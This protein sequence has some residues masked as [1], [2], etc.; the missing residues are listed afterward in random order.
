MMS[1]NSSLVKKIVIVTKSNLLADSIKC[2]LPNIDFLF[3]SNNLQK[4]IDSHSKID[5]LIIDFDCQ[6]PE[7]IQQYKIKTIVTITNGN[8]FLKDEI[9]IS[10][11][12]K[13]NSLLKIIEGTNN[14][15]D[16]F[17]VINDDF[18]YNERLRTLNSQEKLIKLTEKENDI[19]KFMLL[20]PDYKIKKE[21]LLK[22][23]WKYHENS[24]SSTV[25]T[26]LYK[27]KIKL[28]DEMLQL[29][30][31]ICQLNIKTLM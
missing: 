10:K 1:I 9:K 12:F 18:I 16:I 21:S 11:P 4:S 25:D 27:L 20:S 26:H 3:I 30:N 19:F 22:N 13:L 2:N 31:N 23:I 29:R 6:K 24:E 15:K 5:L 28:P 7:A 14:S 17:C 8:K